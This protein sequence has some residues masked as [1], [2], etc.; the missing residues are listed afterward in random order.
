MLTLVVF[1]ALLFVLYFLLLF[2]LFAIMRAYVCA[3]VDHYL[4]LLMLLLPYTI[5]IGIYFEFKTKFLST[6]ER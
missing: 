6:Y 2:V 1:A 5:P 4:Q 3:T